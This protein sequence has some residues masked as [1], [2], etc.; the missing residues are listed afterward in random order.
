[1]HDPNPTPARH[2]LTAL[3][4]DGRPGTLTVRLGPTGRPV[5]LFT[6]DADPGADPRP[7]PVTDVH[8]TGGHPAAL[9]DAATLIEQDAASLDWHWRHTP[10]G[11]RPAWSRPAPDV[12]EHLRA[13]L[14]RP[15][16]TAA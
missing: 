6:S 11:E 1:M 2:V 13:L 12:A 14:P 9:A 7:V 10:P 8:V 5:A 4:A 16:L 3:D 15:A